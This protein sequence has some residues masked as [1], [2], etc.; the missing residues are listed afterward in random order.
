MKRK[1]LVTVF[2]LGLSAAARAGAWDFH[3]AEREISSTR[4]LQPVKIADRFTLEMTL[5]PKAFDGAKGEGM[6][7]SW[8]NGY[9]NG[10][11]LVFTKAKGGYR[12][13]FSLGHED[14]KRGG[15]RFVGTLPTNVWTTL[16]V[17]FDGARVD[18]YRD[19][20]WN[21]TADRPH[22]FA[23]ARP[24]QLALG[25]ARCGISFFPFDCS[26]AE[27]LPR[28]L[29]ADEIAA[30]YM[31]SV[32][33]S[34]WPASFRRRTAD[35]D[36]AH[37]RFDAAAEGYAELYRE[38]CRRASPHRAEIAFAYAD[39]LAQGGKA[40]EA[41]NVCRE[42]A[43]ATDLPPYLTREAAEKA[44]LPDP[45]PAA[46]LPTV[47]AWRPAARTDCVYVIATNGSDAAAG[48]PAAPLA[49]LGAALSRLRARVAEDGWPTGGV[50]IVLRG[51]RYQMAET[52]ELT[53]ADSGAPGAP[54]VICAWPGETVVFDGAREVTAW[55][56]PTAEE[57][58]RLAP[59]ARSH[60]RVADL[61]E[62]IFG[63]LP[64]LQPYGY[65][66]R[67]GKM[68]DLSED[69]RLLTSARHP[70][71]EFAV[72][73]AS[74]R[75]TFTADFGD[76]SGWENE[77]NV[78]ATGYWWNFWSDRTLA[79]ASIDPAANTVTLAAGEPRKK[80][81][82]RAIRKGAAVFL[83]NALRA[84]DAPGEW[85]LDRDARKLYVWPRSA[86]SSRFALNMY[87][88]A[89]FRLAGARSVVLKD[90][91]FEG[92][93]STAVTMDSVS[94][95]RVKG[96]TFRL[97]GRGG[98]RA[99]GARVRIDSCRFYDLGRSAVS[100]SGG[101][102]ETLTRA[103]NLVINC[104]AFNLG[105]HWRTYSP[106]VHTTGCGIDIVANRFHDLPSS[107]IRAD[108]N[109]VRVVSN[110]IW[111]CVLESDDQ[112]AFDI[113]ANPTFAGVE[114]ADNVWEDIGGGDIAHTGQAAVRL[115]DMICGVVIRGNRFVRCGRGIFGA[116]QV[117]GGRR[118]FID[119]NAFVDCRLDVS[120]QSKSAAKW[121]GLCRRYAHLF[122]SPVY[123]ARYPGFSALP[124]APPENYVW[125]SR[126]E[127]VSR[128]IRPRAFSVSPP[129][130]RTAP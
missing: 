10:W 4:A 14:G 122:A 6:V 56:Q 46:P 114:I 44:G 110:R 37:G 102:R 58:S 128:S 3:G 72:V 48:T 34:E 83:T 119:G 123:N 107:A 80:A 63:E 20:V 96:C 67:G 99:S 32:S 19:G 41:K 92:T 29:T 129:G 111:R 64:P 130:E 8:G 109:D 116:V 104:E 23:P 12:A 2:A 115:D 24:A 74:D 60:V 11:R 78:F 89:F 101:S 17:T 103:D 57:A 108:A 66:R 75:E 90:L 30:R 9:N 82:G 105:R 26:R 16:A 43:A 51:G 100:L 36:L 86:S 97:C 84:L 125:R 1:L 22:G 71:A 49:T 126:L 88:G 91:V 5:S 45:H 124:S 117:N 70:N 127:D 81:D 93:C 7:C 120:V 38:A 73:T 28:A 68:I 47:S 113:Y 65:G 112:G 79:V 50:Q 33:K 94:D 35:A 76:L 42:I 55:R 106:A 13:A 21:A 62:A 61:P 52:C 98:V 27:L 87:D 25:G 18:L 69:G 95:I 54:L 40:E 85:Y 77:K 121:A 53:A 118:N 15:V 39:A 59:A 31:G